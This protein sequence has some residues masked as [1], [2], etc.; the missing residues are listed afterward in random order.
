MGLEGT[1]HHADPEANS[2]TPLGDEPEEE[3]DH[4]PAML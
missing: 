2:G 3:R 4:E 1:G